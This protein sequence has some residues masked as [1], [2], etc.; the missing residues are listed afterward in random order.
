[1]SVNKPF[2][3]LF[4][5]NEGYY[6]YDVNRNGILKIK[7]TLWD[8]LFSQC[9]DVNGV[10]S[11]GYEKIEDYKILNEMKKKGFLSS[12]KAQQIIHH[13][14]EVL[15]YHLRNKVQKI[16]LQ[17]T[18]SCNLRC[19]YCPY[20]GGY[21]NREHTNNKMDWNTAKKSLDFLLEHS[22]DNEIVNIGFYGGEPMIEFDLI[23]KC[24][25]YAKEIFKG[26]DIQFSITTNGTLINK[27]IIRYFVKNKV[28]LTISLD[29][30]KEVH[31]KNRRF[32]NGS[33]TFDKIINSLDYIKE[34]FPEYYKR[35]FFNVVL[36]PES[37][38]SC[39]N[40]F[41]CNYE[42]IKENPASLSLITEQY[43]VN[44]IN[45]SQEYFVKNE[46]EYFKVLLS[47]LNRLDSKNV[48][49]LLEKR[50][51]DLRRMYNYIEICERIPE[52][53]HHGGPCIPGVQRLFVNV[54]GDFFPCERVSEESEIMRIGS[55]RNGFELEKIKV[56]LNVGKITEKQCK[57]C[58]AFRFCFQCA[59]FADELDELSSD[60]KLGKCNSVR[61]FV[62]NSFKDICTM[63]EMNFDFTNSF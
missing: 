12:N 11:I 2:I 54:N 10:D 44:S 60:K 35:L 43:S 8:S 23:K 42:T 41:F 50:F 24:I 9:N 13:A 1:M 4:K 19:D 33:G 51:S 36:D 48:S 26:K 3:H 22:I 59:A 15:E 28:N 58:W 34:E 49:K 32:C 29:G 53:A 14:D 40:D 27:K 21:R 6:M 17:V 31:D 61:N 38:F 46:Y 57:N 63:R 52:K 30:P 37:D 16:T 62:V 45:Y 20:S 56:L 39:I 25:E 7:K 47:K 55:I 5:T 18:Q